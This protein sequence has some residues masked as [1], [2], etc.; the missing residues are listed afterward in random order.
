[1]VFTPGQHMAL[2][3]FAQPPQSTMRSSLLHRRAVFGLDRA[4]VVFIPSGNTFH[5]LA[6]CDVRNSG[7]DENNKATSALD[8]LGGGVVYPHFEGTRSGQ[9]AICQA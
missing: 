4:D 7:L 8:L 1:M 9:D 2:W 5:L 6:T 3:P